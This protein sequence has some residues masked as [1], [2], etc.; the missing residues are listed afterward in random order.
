MTTTLNTK[1]LSL[2]DVYRLLGFQKQPIGAYADFLSLEPLTDYEQQE[3][4]QIAKDFETYLT[5]A[6]VSEGLIKVLTLF[7]LLRLAG[8]YRYPVELHLEEAIERI[9]VTDDDV[10]ITGRFDVLAINREAEFGG[11]PFWVLIVE[12]KNSSFAVNVGLPQLLTY[13]YQSLTSQPMVWGMVTNGLDYQFARLQQGTPPTYQ[14]MPTLH[15]FEPDRA[16]QL[17]QSLKAIASLQRG[18]SRTAVA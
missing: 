18:A 9:A 4:A 16:L 2:K 1:N 11:Q 13:A 12:A 5:P 15:L 10:Q 6:K 7:P 8:F 14:L 17:L 3:L